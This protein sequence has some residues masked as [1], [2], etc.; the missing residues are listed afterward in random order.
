[1]TK[2][3]DGK[4]ESD[5]VFMNQFFKIDLTANVVNEYYY[6]DGGYVLPKQEMDSFVTLLKTILEVKNYVPLSEQSTGDGIDLPSF[7]EI[8]V[9]RFARRQVLWFSRM[10][11]TIDEGM[12]QMRERF[13]S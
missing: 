2:G 8:L 3:K 10:N 9:K 6:A 7:G 1:M 4:I 13:Y 5:I 12:V 11:E